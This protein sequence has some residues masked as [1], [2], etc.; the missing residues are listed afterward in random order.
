VIT[1][2]GVLEPDPDSGELVLTSLY[3]G[4]TFDSVAANVGW[5]LRERLGSAQIPPPS[6]ADLALLR[7]RLDPDHLFLKG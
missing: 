3:P 7:E 4:E 1:D 6:A 5:P 2:R